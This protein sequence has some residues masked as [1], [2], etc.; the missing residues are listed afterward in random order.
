VT[1]IGQVMTAP[2]SYVAWTST[3]YPEV[4]PCEFAKGF[5]VAGS[6]EDSQ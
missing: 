1:V 2:D 5:Y 3:E 6:I 4:N